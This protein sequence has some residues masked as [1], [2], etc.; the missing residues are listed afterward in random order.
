[1]TANKGVRV[2]VLDER[3]E[4]YAE[5]GF[6]LGRC[7][8]VLSGVPKELGASMLLRGMNPQLI[9]M[10]EISREGDIEVIEQIIGCGAALLASAHGRGR[11]DMLSRPMYRKLFEMGIF[12]NILTIYRNESRRRYVLEKL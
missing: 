11:E 8:D 3:C 2:A 10:D 4:L 9:A 12:R 7:S 6:D 1:M 5:G